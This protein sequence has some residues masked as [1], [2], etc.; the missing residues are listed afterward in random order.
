MVSFNKQ[1]KSN[2]LNMAGGENESGLGKN[3]HHKMI[4]ILSNWKGLKRKFRISLPNVGE[5]KS[6]KV[7]SVIPFA[8]MWV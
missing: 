6:V 8:P 1:T 3:N 7:K 5:S 2:V 4:N